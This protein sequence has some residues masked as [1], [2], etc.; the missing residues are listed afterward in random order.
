MKKIYIE[1]K[2]VSMTVK[3]EQLL[4]AV[5]GDGVNMRINSTSTDGA[6]DSRSAGGFFDDDED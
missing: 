5:S 4:S 2:T 6:A 3:C 1:P